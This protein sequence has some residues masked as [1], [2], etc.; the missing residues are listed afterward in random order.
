M[1]SSSP[2]FEPT[3]VAGL[4]L[5]NKV[6]MAPMTRWFSPAGVPGNDVAAYYVGRAK[7]EVG[8]IITEGV[9]I[10][11][12]G[13]AGFANVPTMFGEPALSAWTSIVER[14]HDAGGKVIP[15]LWHVG[16]TRRAGP[17]TGPAPG[18][19]PMQVIE[20][21]RVAVVALD[22][23]EIARIR[24]AFADAAKQALHAGFDGV[25]LHG[26][27]GYLL[28]QFMR[29]CTNG[30][31]DGYGGS[32]AARMRLPM[33]IVA[34]IR[35]AAPSTFPIVFRFSQWTMDDYGA[36][37][38]ETPQELEEILSLL[39]SAGTDVFHVSTRRFWE[40]AFDGSPLSLAGWTKK[41][42][43]KPVIAVGSVGLDRA[44]DTVRNRKDS[45]S[46]HADLGDLNERLAAAEF[47]LVA[48]GRGLLADP[49]WVTKV[50]TGC[51]ADLIPVSKHA[52]ET[53]VV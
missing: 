49:Q 31:K 2:L 38:A 29:R 20:G 19:G 16:S 47:D 14:I 51:V 41:L 24:R 3:T 35:R 52:Y 5:R 21:G 44:F 8:L 46:G 45:R 11:H 36:R 22:E 27:H 23:A 1:R 33:E 42:S 6:V 9:N 30:R 4:R 12:P 26:A 13:S 28:D 18:Y 7:A 37:L 48:V 50:R 39:A 25:E 43:G 53:L 17:D 32:L 15:Q 10:D 34:D 40:P